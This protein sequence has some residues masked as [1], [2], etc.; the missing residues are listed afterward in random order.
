MDKPDIWQLYI[1]G[2]AT[3][4]QM[5]PILNPI[6]PLIL[7]MKGASTCV[8]YDNDSYWLFVTTAN[9]FSSEAILTEGKLQN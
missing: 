9:T 1:F 8:P 4:Q 3:W 2:I 7:Q 6:R 5:L